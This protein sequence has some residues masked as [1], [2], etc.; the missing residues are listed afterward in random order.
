M[1]FAAP[2][3]TVETTALTQPP[4]VAAPVQEQ[5]SRPAP[6]E[7]QA[8]RPFLTLSG[9]VTRPPLL[10]EP[11]VSVVAPM[12]VSTAPGAGIYASYCKDC[13]G[14]AAHGNG[15]FASD[16]PVKPSDLTTLSVNAGGAFPAQRV[17]DTVQAAPGAYHRG[18]M[19]QFGTTMDEGLVEWVTPAGE[20]ILAP[21]GLLDV[22]V[23][24][25][26][27]QV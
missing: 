21:Q 20:M 6:V 26:S 24:L 5:A 4:V 14:Q 11:H 13:H 9:P 16:L 18:A 8:A 23:Y 25:E 2:Q 15:R 17:I 3:E 19:P 1:P 10:V 22:L 7:S 27:L 12:E